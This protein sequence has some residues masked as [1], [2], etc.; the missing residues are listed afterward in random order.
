MEVSLISKLPWYAQV[1]A[2]VVLA[3]GGVGGFFYYYEMPARADMDIREGQ[4]KAIRADVAKGLATANQ[5][6]QFRSQVDDLQTRLA[7]L[8]AVL[9][10]EKDAGDFLR[11][12]QIVATQSNL[13]IKSFKPGATVTEQLHAD[14]PI[15]LELDGTYHN[16][17]IFFDR[18]GKFP[19]IV[20]ISGL[21]VKAKDKPDANS[22]ITAKCVATTFVLLDP[23]EVAAGKGGRGAAGRGRGAAPATGAPARAGSPA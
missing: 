2:F 17:A 3:L 13:T 23:A 4:L 10:N 22:T 8:S 20:N 6:S 12:L 21:E 16:L 7:S 11:Q 14:W 18:V 15:A 1:G 19:R 5:L 9:P